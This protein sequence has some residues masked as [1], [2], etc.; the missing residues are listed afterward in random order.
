MVS[1]FPFDSSFPQPYSLH[2]S[3]TS[4]HIYWVFTW[5]SWPWV[6]LLHRGWKVKSK[7]R[8]PHASSPL[9]IPSWPLETITVQPNQHI[10]RPTVADMLR[11]LRRIKPDPHPQA[12]FCPREERDTPKDFVVAVKVWLVWSY[13]IQWL[14]EDTERHPWPLPM[15][16]QQLT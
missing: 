11:Q 8:G 2:C 15:L 12:A 3:S 5:N 13:F 6:L 9:L 4:F 10:L 7:G 14:W 16:Q 1:Y